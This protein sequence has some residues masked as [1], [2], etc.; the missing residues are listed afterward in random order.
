MKSTARGFTLIELLVVI[1]I[2]AILA[3]ILFPV[4]AQAKAAAKGTASLSNT[5]Q[6]ALSHLLYAGDYDDVFTPAAN[7]EAGGPLFL[8]GRRIT[9]WVWNVL[10]YIKTADMMED[11]LGPKMSTPPTGWTKSLVAMLEAS[12][13]L[14]YYAIAPPS[15]SGGAFVINPTSQTQMRTISQT[16]MVVSKFARSESTITFAG[17]WWWGQLEGPTTLATVDPP[18]CQTFWCMVPDAGTGPAWGVG[19]WYETSILNGNLA[20]GARTGGNSLRRSDRMVI[21][22]A[23]GSAGA[24]SPGAMARGTNWSPT[25]NYTSVQI[26]NPE[27]YVWGRE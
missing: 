4:F 5:K 9:T 12:Y 7:Y 19:N 27:E 16:P 11:P 2:I 17:F 10:P 13:G 6:I 20:A 25:Q 3:A 26:T 15:L 21:A 1:A 22:F 24:K 18:F 14:N 8:G 23:D